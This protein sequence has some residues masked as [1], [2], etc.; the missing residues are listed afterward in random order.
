MSKLKDDI[1]AEL[2]DKLCKNFAINDI[3]WGRDD[4][5]TLIEVFV[6]QKQASKLRAELAPMWHGFLTIVI[7]VDPPERFV[8]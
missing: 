5:G 6:L 4:A 2:E 7:G 8:V 3:Q 1:L